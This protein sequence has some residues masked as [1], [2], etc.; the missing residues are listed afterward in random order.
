MKYKNIM[1]LWLV[2]C[3][4]IFFL[5][6]I[7][8]KY[9]S[10][11]PLFG[12]LFGAV[13]FVVIVIAVLVLSGYYAPRPGWFYQIKKALHFL[14]LFFLAVVSFVEI[15]IDFQA[16]VLFFSAYFLALAAIDWLY[17]R[18]KTIP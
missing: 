18:I 11:A 15:N 14:P 8:E 9:D 16:V 2:I 13:M 7:L 1:L 10:V 5:I 4:M 3:S 6:Y 17:Y 12:G